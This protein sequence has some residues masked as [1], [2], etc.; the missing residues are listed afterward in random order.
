MSEWNQIND[1]EEDN[2]F[3][4]PSVQKASQ[5]SGQKKDTTDTTK[6]ENEVPEWLATNTSPSKKDE[7]Q[8]SQKS[9]DN[10]T[11]NNA[12]NPYAAPTQ[13]N[14]GDGPNTK[15][16]EPSQNVILTIRLVNIL[17]AAI[18]TTNAVF[19][20][21]S[22]TTITTGVLC[23]YTAVFCLMMCCYECQIK[24]IIKLMAGNFGFMYNAKSRIIFL[25]FIGIISF[26]INEW[27]R[28]LGAVMIG[29]ALF[30]L[31][32]ICKYPGYAT[33]TVITADELALQYAKNN[34]ELVAKG[35][36]SGLNYAKDNPEVAKAVMKEANKNDNSWA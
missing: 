19:T 11:S 2:P 17:L 7:S 8:E 23:V 18:M 22:L 33:M 16:N 12:Q 4:D 31:F 24:Q 3:A 13:N 9:N 36:S 27:G 6:V 32:V 30:Q 10:V 1:E 35:V 20:I 26:S 29:N 25:I 28:I 15:S 34:P 21:I 14:G 5:Q